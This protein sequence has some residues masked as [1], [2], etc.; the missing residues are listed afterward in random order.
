MNEQALKERI[1]YIANSENR[2]FNQVWRDLILERLL[3][4]LAR[5]SY[6]DQFIF[7]G[8][9]L[10]SYY[11]KLGRETKDMDLQATQLDM[12][13][14]KMEQ[15][16]RKIC[17][18]KVNDGFVY[19]FFKIRELNMEHMNY[20]GY[21][22]NLNLTF[23]N[24]KDRIQVDIAVGNVLEPRRESLQ[25]YQYKGKPIFEGSISLK[26]YPVETICAEK[27]ESVITRGGVNSR[28]KDYHDLILLCREKNIVNTAKLKKNIS[29]SFKDKNITKPFPVKFSNNELVKLQILWKNHRNGLQEIAD[30]L[31]LPVHIEDVIKEINNWL[32]QHGIASISH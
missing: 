22:V 12:N 19:T 11:I 9:L 5:S 7:K 29:E 31:K 27:L 2:K 1:K 24:M 20:P 14:F 13:I 16:I 10:L 15:A 6:S 17:R 30:L 8:G 28:M 21:R 18:V 32:L 3:I 26:V 25:L 4:R 23:G